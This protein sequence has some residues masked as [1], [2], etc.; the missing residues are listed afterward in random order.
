MV[1]NFATNNS[2]DNLYICTFNEVCRIDS[3]QYI[4]YYDSICVDYRS[5]TYAVDANGV[6]TI[7]FGAN[8]QLSQVQYWYPVTVGS[9]TR[10]TLDH[11]TTIETCSLSNAL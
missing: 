4:P 11:P 3:S 5:H 6:Y 9:V 2:S 1:W 8:N 7:P 10:Y